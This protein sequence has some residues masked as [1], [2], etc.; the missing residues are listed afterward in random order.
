MVL[1]KVMISKS[2]RGKRLEGSNSGRHLKVIKGRQLALTPVVKLWQKGVMME[3]PCA[4][5]QG[6]SNMT[7]YVLYTVL[8]K[9][10]SVYNPV[11]HLKKKR[12]IGESTK[13]SHKND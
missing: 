13:E 3:N 1:Q 11:V 8:V 10:I 5:K 4:Y 6:N 7:N 12:Q 2:F 9:W